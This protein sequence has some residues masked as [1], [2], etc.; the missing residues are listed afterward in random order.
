MILP[1]A[2]FAVIFP[3]SAEAEVPDTSTTAAINVSHDDNMDVDLRISPP[4]S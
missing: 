2:G 3:V 1:L 4:Y